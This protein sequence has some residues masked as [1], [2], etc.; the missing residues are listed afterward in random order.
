[1]NQEQKNIFKEALQRLAVTTFS[2]S[3]K[4][5]YGDSYT[6]V[7]VDSLASGRFIAT[8]N[9]SA[10]GFPTERFEYLLSNRGG[11]LITNIVVDGISDLLLKKEQYGAVLK[12]SNFYELIIKINEQI[13]NFGLSGSSS[14][15][16]N[17]SSK[18]K[19]NQNT[20]IGPDIEKYK[21]DCAE[22]FKTG[23]RAY[24]ECVMKLIE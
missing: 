4:G 17:N 6:L 3:V 16:K 23:S 15:E 14:I 5:D 24:G 13:A 20:N 7:K 10:P 18:I 22:L 9:H 1:M 8:Y 12:R 19:V 21:K 11:W 2:K